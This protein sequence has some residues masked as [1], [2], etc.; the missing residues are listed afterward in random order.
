MKPLNNIMNVPIR[1]K[2]GRMRKFDMDVSMD[3]RLYLEDRFRVI[4]ELE[5]EINRAEIRSD[6][7]TL[8]YEKR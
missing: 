2:L 3:I 4:R 7:F 1:L 8:Y 6:L 5:L